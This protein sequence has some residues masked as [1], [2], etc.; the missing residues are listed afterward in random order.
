MADSSR[1][2][3]YYVKESL[4]SV[5]PA[6]AMSALRFTGES[7]GYNISTTTSQEVRADRQVTDLIQTGATASGSVNVEYSFA[8][9]DAL[10]ESALFS[11]WSPAIAISVADDIA[12]SAAGAAFTSTATD[13][14]AAGIVPGQ[15]VR[16]SGFT[17]GG[18]ANNGLYRVVAVA[19]G[20]LGVA[21]AP[22]LDEAATGLTV[23]IAGSMIR[24]GV[25]ET[26]F[27]LEKAFTDVGQFIAMTGMVADGMSLQIQTGRVL[28][29]SFTFTGATAS[30]G[31]AS[32]G[33]GAPV[34]APAHPVMNAVNNVGHIMEAGAPLTGGFVQ[35]LS[36]SLANGIRGIGA[37]GRLGNAD[38]GTGRCQ[39]T[40]GV[41][42]YFADGALYGK[43]LA[44]TPT[45]LSFRV[46][47]AV[48]NAYV[49]TLPRV[50]LTQGA[51]VAGGPDQD[52]V[53]D[54]QYQALRDPATNA[55]IQIDRLAA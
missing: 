24:N 14:L 6:A 52:I 2:Q 33:S 20:S 27:T 26:S 39:V 17:A 10:I 35:S 31:T 36:V 21:P 30:I 25:A 18:G 15:W 8:A 55:T 23:A 46:T 7:L 41:S 48:G 42:L 22:A 38:L 29:G 32:V 44:G 19:A 1:A 11:A 12:A 4:W 47:D 49:F 5:T 50:K 40:G 37:V 54:F 53:A 9:Y 3:L 43:Y 28:T 16:V 13:F 34:A 45:S 51:I